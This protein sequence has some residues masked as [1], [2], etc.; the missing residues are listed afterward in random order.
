[1]RAGFTTDPRDDLFIY[2]RIMNDRYSGVRNAIKPRQI[3]RLVVRLDANNE[4]RCGERSP[5]VRRAMPVACNFRSLRAVKIFN[6]RGQE[7]KKKKKK[8]AIDVSVIVRGQPGYH[9][10][11]ED[12]KQAETA[13]NFSNIGSKSKCISL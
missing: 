9:A 4:G 11:E 7:K 13:L 3:S 6:D 5:P 8:S 10:I 12:T 2:T 1:M